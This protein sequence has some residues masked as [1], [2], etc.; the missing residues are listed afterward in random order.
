MLSLPVES[1]GA[2]EVAFPRRAK[3]RVPPCWHPVGKGAGDEPCA[4][5]G[6]APT[7]AATRSPAA[8]TWATFRHALVTIIPVPSSSSVWDRGSH[9]P[10]HVPP[11]AHGR[12]PDGSAAQRSRYQQ[13]DAPG[14]R[15]R[16]ADL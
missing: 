16:S 12:H 1:H 8:A 14:N 2:N 11:L 5:T 15:M 9:A 7:E 3:V 6:A 13:G 10:A 4:I